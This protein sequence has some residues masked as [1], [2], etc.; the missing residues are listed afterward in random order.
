MRLPG[1][2]SVF[3][4]GVLAILALLAWRVAVLL[5]EVTLLVTTTRHVVE[6][7][8]DRL[9]QT[10][11]REMDKTRADLRVEVRHLAGQASS[12]ITAARELADKHL[13]EIE[14]LLDHRLSELQG[15]LEREVAKVTDPAGSLLEQSNLAM[16]TVGKR[17]DFYTN[18]DANGFCWQGLVTDSLVS[19]RY[20]MRSVGMAAP[21]VSKNLEAVSSN[22]VKLS[23]EA[24]EI[25]EDIHTIT[26]RITRPKKWYQKL[27]GAVIATG[28][29][30]G[31]ILLF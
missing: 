7:L 18:C 6:Q 17:L 21:E 14:K 30:V 11:A 29:V 8:P 16:E 13:T 20:M 24:A 9:D 31:G 3:L 12:Q 26:D 23:N 19:A 22:I 15:S 28:K 4:V 25:S 2:K 1:S 5:Q 27:W 10:I